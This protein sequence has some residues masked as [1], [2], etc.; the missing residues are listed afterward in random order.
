MSSNS[1]VYWDIDLVICMEL[2]KDIYKIVLKSQVQRVIC[3]QDMG[4]F[5]L[6]FL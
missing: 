1:E 3:F 6:A 5:I 4:I 2:Y